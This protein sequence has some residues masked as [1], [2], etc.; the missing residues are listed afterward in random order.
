[1]F[2]E[3]VML[4]LNIMVSLISITAQRPALYVVG[5]KLNTLSPSNIVF[6]SSPRVAGDCRGPPLSDILAEY[7]TSDLSVDIVPV[8]ISACG[9]YSES[10]LVNGID[11]IQERAENTTYSIVAFGVGITEDSRSVIYGKVSELSRANILVAVAANTWS[12]VPRGVFTVPIERLDRGYQRPIACSEQQEEVRR[13]ERECPSC[14]SWTALALSEIVVIVF[15]LLV[16]SCMLGRNHVACCK[17]AL[18]PRDQTNSG[19]HRESIPWYT[20][21]QS[22]TPRPTSLESPQL[23]EPSQAASST[24]PHNSQEVAVHSIESM[25]RRA[26]NAQNVSPSTRL[27]ASQSAPSNAL[28]PMNSNGNTS[29]SASSPRSGSHATSISFGTAIVQRSNGDSFQRSK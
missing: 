26:S 8:S 29:E 13:W 22:T 25:M 2:C 19:T 27:L 18:H 21:P 15:M 5:D 28:W 4:C 3:G 24:S 6:D 7:I 16:I 9:V 10:D 23:T 12:Y 17:P 20:S 1:M 14:S 11:W